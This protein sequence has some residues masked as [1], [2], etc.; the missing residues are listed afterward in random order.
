MSYSIRINHVAVNVQSREAGAKLLRQVLR[1]VE[2]AAKAMTLGGPYTTG[3]LS[4]SIHT[5]GPE[6]TPTGVTGSVGSNLYYAKIVHDGAKVHAIYPKGRSGG[7]R[8]PGDS[9]YHKRPQ[10]KF[11]WRRAG[12]VVFFPQI[13]ASPR[14]VLRSHPGQKDK[15]YLTRPLL[16]AAH[17]HNMRVDAETL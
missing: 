8:F 16:A 10:L 5:R 14:T 7:A 3:H 15:Q 17:R 1:E 13:P 9:D 12:K 4:N 2:T 6:F 11:Y